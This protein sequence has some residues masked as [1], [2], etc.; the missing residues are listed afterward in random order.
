MEHFK[1]YS[2][3]CTI[4]SYTTQIYVHPLPLLPIWFNWAIYCSYNTLGQIAKSQ[5]W[6]LLKHYILQTGCHSNCVKAHYIQLAY[7]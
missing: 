1:L 2:W 6:A 5:L 7:K 3:S 4:Q